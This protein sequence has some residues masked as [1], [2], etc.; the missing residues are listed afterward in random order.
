[1]L[2]R[3]RSEPEDEA[4]TFE[5]MA[6]E[7]EKAFAAQ[8]VKAADSL[9][10]NCGLYWMQVFAAEVRKK[11]NQWP[12]GEYPPTVPWAMQSRTRMHFKVCG[13]ESPN[14]PPLCWFSV[15]ILIATM[16][17]HS[18]LHN[19]DRSTLENSYRLKS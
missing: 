8:K 2:E 14:T 16:L 15:V 5:D 13:I 6:R 17:V 4:V 9:D 3:H 1:M 12:E 19:H 11:K 18:W 10:P 7:V